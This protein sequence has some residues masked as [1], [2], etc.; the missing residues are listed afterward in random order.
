MFNHFMKYTSFN[1][2]SHIKMWI[3]LI[4][5]NYHLLKAAQ[6]LNFCFKTRSIKIIFIKFSK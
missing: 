5:I 2:D 3:V 6:A 1:V 4:N